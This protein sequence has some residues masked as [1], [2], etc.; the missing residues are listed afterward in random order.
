[1]ATV[2]RRKQD[3]AFKI[4]EDAPSEETQMNDDIVPT[5]ACTIQQ[6]DD[7]DQQDAEAEEDEVEGE[8]DDNG[9]QED[10]DDAQDSSDDDA[11]DETV[12]QDME[13]LQA[14]FPSFR[15]QFRLIKR[16]GE[17]E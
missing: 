9:E 17:G 16:I 5:D 15:Q 10:E 8:E 1:M 3:E 13:K 6:Y 2:V 7:E 4:H 11:V 12:Q 14:T